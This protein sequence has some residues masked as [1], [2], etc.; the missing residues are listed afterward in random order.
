MFKALGALVA[1][2]TIYAAASGEVYAKSGTGGRTVSR[3]D[4]PGYF[5]A[6]IGIYAGL[7]F[8]LIMVF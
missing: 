5:W 4:S 1:L 2:Y 6:V 3:Q 8:A 7:S